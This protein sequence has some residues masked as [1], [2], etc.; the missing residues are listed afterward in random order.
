MDA[1]TS[2]GAPRSA[3][4]PQKLRERLEELLTQSLQTGKES[5][6]VVLT[7]PVCCNLLPQPQEIKTLGKPAQCAQSGGVP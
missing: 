7:H 3:G 5:V 1:A 2:P 4:G 6:S